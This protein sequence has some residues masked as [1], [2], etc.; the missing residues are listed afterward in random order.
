[1][2]GK[3]PRIRYGFPVKATGHQ[4][5]LGPEDDPTGIE[6]LRQSLLQTIRKITNICTYRKLRGREIRVETQ[7]IDQETLENLHERCLMQTTESEVHEMIL[8]TKEEIDAI[9]WEYL[10]RVSRNPV[11]IAMRHIQSILQFI[12]RK[13]PLREPESIEVLATQKT[14]R[15]LLLNLLFVVRK[16]HQNASSKQDD[17]S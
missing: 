7:V 12:L 2:S 9:D 17:T 15:E 13:T 1:M 10:P 11:W 5:E 4:S 16:L 6:P 8:K 14:V 3:C